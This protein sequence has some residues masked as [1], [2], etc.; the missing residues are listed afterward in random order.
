MNTPLP[1]SLV[2]IFPLRFRLRDELRFIH[3]S[4]RIVAE[5]R[6]RSQ[7]YSLSGWQFEMLSRLD[8]KRS[9]RDISKEVYELKPGSFTAKGLLNFYNWLCLEDLI[10]CECESIFELVEESA[11]VESGAESSSGLF[12]DQYKPSKRMVQVLK[13]SAAVI[14]SLSVLRLAYVAAPIFEP[15]VN[16]LYAEVGELMRADEPS[17]S[18]AKSERSVQESSVQKVEIASKAVE[19]TP[20]PLEMEE[21]MALPQPEAVSEPLPE[22]EPVH[23]SIDDLRVKLEECRIRRDEFYLQNN[24]QGY[25]HEVQVMTE[26]AKEIGDIESGL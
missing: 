14:F 3:E 9:F 25:R 20:V 7:R 1:G 2:E 23:S 17:V 6:E 15:P 22:A 21:P 4:Q 5:R 26:L 16:R 19:K 10:L 18:L 11:G 8:G 24:E 12:S 13:L